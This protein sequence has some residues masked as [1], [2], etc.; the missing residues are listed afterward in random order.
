MDPEQQMDDAEDMDGAQ[1]EATPDDM[2]PSQ[3]MSQN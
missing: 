3:H 1:M 2:D